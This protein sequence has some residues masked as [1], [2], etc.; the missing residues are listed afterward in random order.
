MGTFLGY[1]GNPAIREDKRQEFTEHVLKILDQGGMMDVETVSIFGRNVDLLQPPGVDDN[2]NVLFCCNFFENYVWETGLYRPATAQL[3]TNKVGTRQF[4]L[5]SRALYV[6]NEFY[7]ET[8]GIAEEDGRIYDAERT[9]GWL[10]ELFDERYDNRRVSDLWEIYR[11]LPEYRRG[12]DLMRLTK[13]QP[14]KETSIQGFVKYFVIAGDAFDKVSD[15]WNTSEEDNSGLLGRAVLLHHRVRL[16]RAASRESDA[17]QMA[18]MKELLAGQRCGAPLQGESEE[19]EKLISSVPLEIA[20]KFVADAYGLDFWD[21]LAEF[22][23]PESRT[24]LRLPEENYTPTAKVSTGEY[25]GAMDDDRAWWWKPGGNI[26][27]SAEMNGW[28]EERR[29]E[30]RELARMETIGSPELMR[31]LVD[32]LCCIQ[33]DWNTMAFGGMFYDFLA[34]AE[35]PVVQ[36][37]VRSIGRLAQE[38]RE[39]QADGLKWLRRYLAV[40]GNF[41]LRREVFGF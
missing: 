22:E 4:N 40:L 39:K 37:A 8:F 6:L 18:R 2:G 36:A 12:D 26:C 29:E 27:F 17:A 13:N 30:L 33:E 41:D 25:L 7:A 31:L 23:T 10:N 15:A 9:I 19:L 16:F 14:V 1:Y 35:D 34:H 28:L 21:L 32:T 5:V 38:Y 11:L 20:V 24:V 3:H